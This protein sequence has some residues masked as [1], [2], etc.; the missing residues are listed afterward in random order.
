MLLLPCVRS[1]R[2]SSTL[3]LVGVLMRLVDLSSGDG[4]PGADLLHGKAAQGSDLLGGLPSGGSPALSE[5]RGAADT[6][7]AA[8]AQ[9]IAAPGAVVYEYDPGYIDRK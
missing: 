8:A 3:S 2:A 5:E 6:A 9:S 1:D 7:S 4:L